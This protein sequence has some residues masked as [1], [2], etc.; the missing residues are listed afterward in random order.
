MS[1]TQR[2]IADSVPL[3]QAK[4]AALLHDRT[5]GAA[6]RNA[7]RSASDVL[8]TASSATA[9]SLPLQI[10]LVTIQHLS[11]LS[12]NLDVV[13][14]RVGE[15]RR[16]TVR[17]SEIAQSSTKDILRYF[18][19]KLHV[20]FSALKEQR[21]MLQPVSPV[22]ALEH[23]LSDTDLD[24]L[25]S[26]VRAAI[27]AHY[28]SYYE[29][30]W[31]P[32]VVY[33]AEMGY[34][35]EGD[36]YWITFSSV[37]PRWTDQERSTIR[38]WFVRFHNRYG[39]ARPTGAWANHFTIIAWPITHAVLP[40]YLQR[41]LAQLIY[42]FR[43]GL[44]KVLLDDPDALGVRLAARSGWYSDRFR[45]F[46]QNTQLVGQVAAA[47]LSGDDDESPYLVK[48][49]LDRLIKGLSHEQQAHQWLT[50]A[51]Q[52]ANRVRVSGFSRGS[53]A[54]SRAPS[55]KEQLPRATDPRLILR[56]LDGTWYAYAELPDMTPLNER[57]PR[58]Y[59][60]LR[61]KRGRVNGGRRPVP[62]GGLVYGGQEVRF[63]TWPDPTKPFVQLERGSD[64]V[65]A[66]LADQAVMTSGPWWLFRQ[67]GGGT[68]VEVKGRFLR[69]GHRYILIGADGMEPPA[70][71]WCTPT[72]LAA[73]GAKAWRLDVSDPLPDA[74]AQ[75]LV[76]SGLSS[77]ASVAIRP[78]GLVASAWDGEGAAEWLAAEPVILGIRAEVA[79]ARSLITINGD[80]HFVTWPVEQ[81]ELIVSIDSLEV[82]SHSVSAT[83]VS[84]DDEELSHGE[85][86]ITVR[87]PQ[88][89]PENATVGEGIR[90]L[91]SPARPTLAE[92]WDDRATVTVDSPPETKAEMV[93]ALL[94]ED[95]QHLGAIRRK[96]T[97]PI[98]EGAW[99][100]LAGGIRRASTFKSHYDEAQWCTVT[101]QRDGIGMASLSCERGFQPLR[102][103]FC[104]D[105]DGSYTARLHDQTDGGNTKVEFYAVEQPLRA[106]VHE[107][108]ADIPLPPR[109]GLLRAT[110]DGVEVA[111]LAPT[112]PN[113]VFAM[114]SMAPQV[115]YSDNSTAGI[116][117]L[118]EA[119]W[120]WTSADLPAD[121]FAVHEQQLAIDAILRAASM[122]LCGSH[123]ST[124]ENKLATASA[125]WVLDHLG[126]M[127]VAIGVSEAHK[128]LAHQIS[129]SLYD[130]SL[131]EKLLPGFA[132]VITPTLR[133]SGIKSP[134]APRF[135][136]TMAGRLGYITRQWSAAD[137][138]LLLDR[139]KAS[140]VLLRAARY[141]VIGSRAFAEQ[142]EAQ[143]GF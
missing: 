62:T 103:R 138:T 140:P 129:L 98:D 135:L 120:L 105:R 91:A 53:S 37:T 33:A 114:G 123:W 141:A 97:L 21:A 68:A 139:I 20:H 95:R 18:H 92:L 115:R 88:V 80:P 28:V 76:A 35:Y 104:K 63:E 38:D 7:V 90:L 99:T 89:R 45:N 130:W 2:R 69:P 81:R 96:V 54:G 107:T 64:P 79:P 128:A 22:F 133:E 94:S 31:L 78:V 24:L 101:V 43:T 84:A 136:L 26:A 142:E 127:E 93:V 118:A 116:M 117:R 55:K 3:S 47:L 10:N 60:E 119:H 109:G 41:Q 16:S 86:T 85:L 61:S 83:L 49:T 124:I 39:G 108:G 50:S 111:V 42:E 13:L 51:K 71:S 87:D 56:R 74:D 29:I 12:G 102:W 70:V 46:C 19:G 34:D 73:T 65:N 134:S 131:P 8:N 75:A 110:A 27:E 106:I 44:T 30:T 4:S 100:R 122:L 11:E 9:F 6:H 48:S 67:Q 77:L 25:K 82:G 121:P 143:R 52:A 40:V 66:L 5:L 32:F 72:A 1:R 57:L 113:Q 23:D 58:L 59:D 112:Q 125:D 14:A 17:M 126:D 132:A 36:E 15:E 137:R